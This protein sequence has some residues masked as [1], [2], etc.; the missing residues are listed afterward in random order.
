MGTTVSAEL[1]HHGEQ[2]DRIGR[3]RMPAERRRQLLAAFRE[4][5][6]TRS[7]FARREGIRYTTFCTWVQK[8]EEA[9]AGGGAGMKRKPAAPTVRFAQVGLPPGAARG[10]EVRLPDGITV[11]GSSVEEL[12]G[13]VRA[14]RR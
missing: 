6:L 14:L 7:G 11:R 9:R 10:L 1:V 3:Q 12:A 2:R 8:D 5:G 4:S 13:L